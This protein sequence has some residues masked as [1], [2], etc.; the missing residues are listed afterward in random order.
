MLRDALE[1]FLEAAEW[2][3]CGE[4][5]PDLAGLR[6]PDLDRLPSLPDG[7][8]L[9]LFLLLALDPLSDSDPESVS[10]E[11]FCVIGAIVMCFN[12]TQV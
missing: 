6:E 5:L 1:D 12:K 7:A 9:G 11:T 10:S 2:W 4:P 3:D 8:G